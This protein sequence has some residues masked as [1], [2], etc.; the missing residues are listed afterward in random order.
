MPLDDCRVVLVRPEVP[1]NIGATARVM[2]NMGLS[3]LGLIAPAAD[4]LDV[5]ARQMSAQAEFILHRA[6]IVP[7]LDS[8]LAEC[9]VVAGTSANVGGPYRRQ[10]AGPPE[11]IMPSLVEALDTGPVALV[12]GP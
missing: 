3:R 8:A 12:F 4:P 9:V 2:H 7:D 5:R 11:L 10:S 1:G 6:L